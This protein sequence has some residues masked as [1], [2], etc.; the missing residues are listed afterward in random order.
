MNPLWSLLRCPACQGALEYTAYGATDG[1]L[2]SACGLW[3]PV[4]DEIPR[5]FIGEMRAVYAT[6]FADFLARHGLAE[7]AAPAG[8]ETRAKLQ[9]RESFGF[10]WTHFSEMLPEWERNA[11]FYFE[12]IDGDAGLRG[13]LVFEG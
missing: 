3:F 11:R 9:T 5:I 2:R 8:A 13:A 1:L 7:N 6:D 10:E 4:I 12:P